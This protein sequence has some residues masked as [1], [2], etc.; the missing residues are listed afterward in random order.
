MLLADEPTGNLD[1]KTGRMIVEL[2]SKLSHDGGV[3]VIIVT[4][5]L[6][7]AK[8]TDVTFTLSAGKRVS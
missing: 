1:S 5:D 8:R 2:L 6:S 4:H 7:F 3:T